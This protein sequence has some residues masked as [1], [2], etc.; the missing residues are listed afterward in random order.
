MLAEFSY[1]L[2]TTGSNRFRDNVSANLKI[3]CLR[4]R[5]H[6]KVPMYLS[7]SVW[8]QLIQSRTAKEEKSSKRAQTK[9]RSQS[10]E[11]RPKINLEVILSILSVWRKIGCTFHSISTHLTCI[12]AKLLHS[13][14]TTTTTTPITAAVTTTTTV[15]MA[16]AI[17]GHYYYPAI[18][19]WF[20]FWARVCSFSV[21]CDERFVGNFI[22]EVPH[23]PCRTKLNSNEMPSQ[24]SRWHQITLIILSSSPSRLSTLPYPTLP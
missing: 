21:C 22:W 12:P 3:Y 13:S 7:I 2:I 17:Y 23:M 18:V 20:K 11:E 24:I 1:L 5:P 14:T 9:I 16:A 19:S 8:L 10:D 4:R 15:A 6:M